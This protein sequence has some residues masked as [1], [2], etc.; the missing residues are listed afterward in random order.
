MTT[1]DRDAMIRL[2][3]APP[4]DAIAPAELADLIHSEILSTPQRR[5][6]LRLG[7]L[8]WLPA[9]SPL[10]A[11]LVVLSTLA[12]ALLIAALAR[13]RPAVL[14]TYHGGPDRTGVMP[15]PGPVGQ[16]V[17][18]WD[19]QRPGA[20]PFTSMPL[21]VGDRVIVADE[22]GTL[23]ALDAATG[24]TIWELDVGSPIH[25]APSVVGG[26]VVVGSDGGEVVAVSEAT[27]SIVWRQ[28]LHEG[29]ILTAVLFADNV[30]Y[31][32]T[33][34]G[35]VFAL[36]P[37][38]GRTLWSMDVGSS[39]SR[40]PS[41]ADAIL[42]IGTNGGT[43]LAIDVAT[44]SVRWS[45]TLAPGEVGTPA[46]SGGRVYV[47][48]GLRGDGPDHPL[49]ALDARDGR[50]LWT[51]FA[52]GGEQVHLGAIA[53]G[54]VYAAAENGFLYALD[55]ETG[56]ELWASRVGG[57]LATLATVAGDVVY[58]GTKDRST[59]AIDAETG[60]ELWFVDV[61]GEPT[62]AAVLDGRV[63]VGTTLGRVVAI[64]GSG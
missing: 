50:V 12:V 9:P 49:V 41:Y 22:S 29:G 60:R 18:L 58:V 21:P 23:A 20:V 39:V 43:L 10:A 63:F 7:R 59:H 3:I 57:V 1:N 30:V 14:S 56:N 19:V 37:S 55:P 5:G 64:G 34:G 2:A 32:G 25:G 40:S 26:L 62:M 8:G 38:D 54:R 27:A 6:L 31:A 15:G 28:Q 61:A 33:E 48:T 42:Y 44:Q 46:V 51:F 47:G 45:V 13:P 53:Y 16:P 35:G 24:D 36:S 4:A 11:A 17:V 52:P